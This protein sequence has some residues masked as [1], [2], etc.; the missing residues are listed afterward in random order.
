MD[1]GKLVVSIEGDNSGLDKA[2]KQSVNSVD[3]AVGQIAGA[4]GL[5]A[6]AWK[7][8][9]LAIQGIKFNT[10][11]ES[12]QTSFGIMLG[13]VD[14]AK[15]KLSE[16]KYLADHSPLT[17][18]GVTA[19]TTTLLQFGVAGD[20]VIP[21][22]K[23]LGDVAGGNEQRMQQLALAFAQ[24]S[25][26]GKIQGQD[27]LQMINAGYNPLM[28]ISQK[29]GE[30]MAE[31]RKRMEQGGISAQEVADAFKTVT[32]EGGQFFGM[33]ES[34]AKTLEGSFTTLGDASATFLGRT[35]QA[36]SGPLL[37]GVQTLTNLLNMIPGEFGAIA[38]T[39][40]TVT[41]GVGAFALGVG[42][43]TP[44][45]AALGVTINI[46]LL[47]LLGVTAT[48]AA[49]GTAVVLVGKAWA[50]AIPKEERIKQLT[51]QFMDQGKTF[52]EATILAR[53]LVDDNEKNAE[54]TKTMAKNYQ[55]YYSAQVKVAEEQ[56]K[57]DESRANSQKQLTA[58]LKV[59]DDLARAGIVSEQDALKEKVKIRQKIID[60]IK[61]EAVK[62]GAITDSDKA[63]IRFQ[64][65]A[66]NEYTAA[67]DLAN[68]RLTQGT[69]F[70]NVLA[71][72]TKQVGFGISANVA[73][74]TAQKDVLQIELEK[75]S[76]ITDQYMRQ[77]ALAQDN[78]DTV[79]D[80][81]L[82]LGKTTISM[83]DLGTTFSGAF[84]DANKTLKEM[85]LEAFRKSVVSTGDLVKSSLV[86]SFMQWGS[87]LKK[88]ED[89]WKGIGDI[90]KKVLV[91]ILQGIAGQ[92][93]GLAVV[94]ALALDFVGAGIALAAAAAAGT[95]AGVVSAFA[96]GT[97]S[98]PGG[99]ALVGERGPELVNLPKG[100]QVI[101]NQQT[102][103]LLK[104]GNT[105]TINVQSNAPLD[106]IETARMVKQTMQSLAFR[107]VA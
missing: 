52:R 31:L 47:P 107:G 43:L 63:A 53:Q 32:S 68:L 100:S 23:M 54:L 94:H 102:E 4:V 16:L 29:T 98:A 91:G 10:M 76:A 3:Q 18:S 69:D 45:F 40:G 27:L 50:D 80:V 41:A 105:Y 48:I 26:A 84:K 83:S 106:P 11:M 82:A 38:L 71:T 6:A 62:K 57:A 87:A 15:A 101:P 20:Q 70:T 49:I 75:T 51:A 89:A 2:L 86:D 104:G 99:I 13:S 74:L 65:D 88:G 42:A 24:V 44:A 22:V 21:T 95:A 55:D 28:T 39:V 93:A 35:T 64:L 34:K 77:E 66:I 7:G 33:M 36:F 25:A 79:K 103:S 90:A 12:A 96:D 61:D 46:A 97:D 37:A 92:L 85:D 30:S 58:Q 9:D 8:M 17:F 72:A 73:L 67:I 59:Y 1:L 5:G 14:E 78:L 19:A 81:A 60:S 56:K